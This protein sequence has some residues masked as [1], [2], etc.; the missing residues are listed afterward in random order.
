MMVCLH[1]KGRIEGLVAE[2]SWAKVARKAQ[3]ELAAPE[4]NGRWEPTKCGIWSG[5]CS[6][7]GVYVVENALAE[8]FN[9]DPYGNIFW[10]PAPHFN[11][12]KTREAYTA[13]IIALESF[14]L[15]CEEHGV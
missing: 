12:A 2:K 15:Y 9:K 7:L 13:R 1:M 4:L 6:A 3:F 11:T 5:C 8:F 10:W 14:A